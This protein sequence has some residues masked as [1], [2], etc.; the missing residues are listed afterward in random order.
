MSGD[1]SGILQNNSDKECLED[2][3]KED[4]EEIM[5]Q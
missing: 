5:Y 4:S 3:G 1:L 2:E